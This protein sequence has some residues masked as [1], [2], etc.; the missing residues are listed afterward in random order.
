MIDKLANST[1]PVLLLGE[2]GSGKS[3]LA[4]ELHQRSARRGAF[5]S[6]SLSATSRELIESEL[7]GHEA[8][9]FTGAHRLRRGL[10]EQARGGTLFLDEIGEIS[11]EQQKKLLLVLEE[12]CF[13]R[14]GGEVSL[15]YDCKLIFATNQNLWELM[16]RGEFRADLYYRICGH[17]YE[18][19]SLRKIVQENPKFIEKFYEELCDQGLRRVVID[20]ACLEWLNSRSWPG[21]IRQLKMALQAGI[22]LL[23]PGEM[24]LTLAVMRQTMASCEI[25]KQEEGRA[26]EEWSLESPLTS[27]H[28]SLASFERRYFRCALE[29][30][31]GRINQISRS[32]GINKTTLLAKLRRYDMKAEKYRNQTVKLLKACS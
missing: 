15:P 5:V 3:H 25:S 28:E 20:E 10:F 7:F 9:A 24:R 21:N 27:Y 8:G 32:L 22:E 18:V 14:V 30:Y 2:T 1:L 19:D 17:R 12:K 11:L 6:A 29:E 26:G 31:G 16:T 13:K 23:A 4:R